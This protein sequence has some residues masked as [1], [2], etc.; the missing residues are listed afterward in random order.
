LLRIRR[1]LHGGGLLFLALAATSTLALADRPMAPAAA[2]RVQRPISEDPLIDQRL[3]ALLPKL[4][5]D[6]HAAAVGPAMRALVPRFNA[7]WPTA[8]EITTYFGEV[9]RLSPHGHSG[10]DIAAPEGWPVVAA[11]DGE[12]LKAYWNKD[13]Y[14]GLVV[15]G[16]PSGFETWYGHLDRF[17]VDSGDLVKRGQQIALMGSTGFSTGA[18]LHFEIRQDGQ[19]CDPLQFLNEAN[20]K[21]AES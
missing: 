6:Q 5:T 14:G 4:D 7:T 3:V 2:T 18:H 12:V 10:L 8:G 1:V 19:L 21:P 20:L 16:H 17:D 15:I 11:D 13:G 9:S